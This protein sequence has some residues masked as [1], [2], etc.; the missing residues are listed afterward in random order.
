MSASPAWM[1]CP[2]CT[3]RSATYPVTGAT[4][5]LRCAA[6]HASR[7]ASFAWRT[8]G[9]LSIGVPS[10]SACADSD[11]RSACASAARA[12]CTLSW[13]CRTSSP[14]MAC[15]ATSRLRIDGI[16]LHQYLSGV[17]ELG[18]VRQYRNHGAGNLRRNHDAVAIHV[19]IIG[20]FALGKHQYPV[21]GPHRANHDEDHRDE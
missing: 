14:A 18:V 11:W 20:F 17:D 4:T 13:A 6:I 5:A 1:C 2:S 8:V 9:L 16:E 7:Y 10:T 15:S 19:G 12:S 21:R 3:L